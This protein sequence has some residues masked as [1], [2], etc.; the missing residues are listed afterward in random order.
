MS[1]T[2]IFSVDRV[3]RYVLERDVY[4]NL[5]GAVGNLTIGFCGVNPSDADEVKDDQ[6]VKKWRIFAGILGGR[7]YLAFNPLAA[8]ATNVRDLAAMA[9]PV[10]PLNPVHFHDSIAECDIVVPCWG[11]ASKLPPRLRH[12]LE[13]AKR[14]IFLSG[15]P[16]KIFGLTKSGD[17]MHPL[18]LGYNTQLIDWLLPTTHANEGERK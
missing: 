12:H 3:Y 18:M 9:D 15:K 7:R 6:T 17:P 2:A 8:V 1:N 11:N 5:R 14:I 4:H 13:E 16:V 10:G